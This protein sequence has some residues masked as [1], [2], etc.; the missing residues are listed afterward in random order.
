MFVDELTFTAR[1][2]DGGDGVVRW[3]QQKFQPKGGPAGGNGGQGG[4]VYIRAVRDINRL[5]KYTGIKEFV[6][7]SGVDGGGSDQHGKNGDDFYLDLPV[8]SVVR[9]QERDREYELLEEGEEIRILRGGKGG[10]GNAMFKSSTNRSPQQ[11]TEGTSGE[12]GTFTVEVRL[13]VD[14]GFIGLPNAGKSTLLNTLTNA[15]ARVGAYPF[16]TLEPHLGELYGFVLADIPGLIAG[17]STGKGLGD[18]FLRHVQRTNMLVHCIA[19]DTDDVVETYRTVRDELAA[20]DDTLLQKTEWI[21]LTKS[22]IAAHDPADAKAAL[23]AAGITA[24]CYALSAE[25]GEGV[26]EFR[27]ALVSHLRSA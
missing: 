13:V 17:A 8:G 25:S 16:T 14:A 19:L 20:F 12:E 1:A 7:E 23:T 18:K 27:D 6:A 26:K 2:G 5:S 15:T 24:P 10:L 21:V 22:D 11:A 9:E 4:D 3:R